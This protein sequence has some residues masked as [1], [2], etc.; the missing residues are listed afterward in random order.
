MQIA[1]AFVAA[2]A[3][4]IVELSLGFHALGDG[5]HVECVRQI[6]DGRDQRA[7]FAVGGQ[8]GREAAVDLQ[9][10]DRQFRQSP[11]GGKPG[12]K[13]VDGDPYAR[14]PQQPQRMYACR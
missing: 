7:A 8:P 6:D 3:F 10:I 4:E 13:I 9:R 2:C 12:P 5:G 11:Q 1:L 14:G